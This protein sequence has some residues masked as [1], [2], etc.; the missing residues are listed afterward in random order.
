MERVLVLGCSG[1][2]KSTLSRT[3]A[4]RLGLPVIHLDREYWRPGWRETPADEFDRRV[5]ELVAAPRWVMDGNFARTLEPRLARADTVVYLDFPV[6]RCL[7]GVCKRAFLACNFDRPRPDMGP[8]CPERWDWEFVEWV[9]N[10][11]RDER[12]KTLRAIA[13]RGGGVRVIT[14]TNHRQVEG[15]LDGLPRV[16][17]GGGVAGDAGLPRC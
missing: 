1:A 2:G 7:Y 12:P 14:L 15:F 9:V 8:G 6:W 17:D 10:F 3:L 5:A 16:R 4:G 11:R 13:P